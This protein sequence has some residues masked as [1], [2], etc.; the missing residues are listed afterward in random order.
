MARRIIR[1]VINN[2]GYRLEELKQNL[3]KRNHPEKI[4]NFSFTKS[5]QPKNNKEENEEM[6]TIT[7]TYNLNQNFN[8][9]CFINCFN[10][11]NQEHPSTFSNKKVLLTKRQ[12]KKR[13]KNVI[14]KMLF[15]AK[16]DLHPQ[17]PHRKP[18]RLFSSTDCIYHK[19]GYI[20]PCKSFTF[21]LTNGISVTSNYNKFFDDDSKDVLYILIF[22]NC[23]YFYFGKTMNFKQR[24]RKQKL[25][26]KH[27]QKST[28]RECAQHLRDCAKSE[29]FF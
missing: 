19:N 9:N 17:L 12:R 4:I 27:P 15:A 18:N 21:K 13:K 26:L 5:F 10:V 14:K 1:I 8:Y 24:I 23:D 22:N 7:R 3:L 2:P 20:K 29:P 6:V 25:V 28:C 16:F 11:N